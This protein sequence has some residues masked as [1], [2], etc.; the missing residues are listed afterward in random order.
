[1]RLGIRENQTIANILESS[2]STVYT[3]K[4]RI[5]GKALFHG[6]EFDQKVMEIKFVDTT[7]VQT[8]HLPQD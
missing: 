5:K 4:N 1:M 7:D 6:D 2:L 8:D 3:Y